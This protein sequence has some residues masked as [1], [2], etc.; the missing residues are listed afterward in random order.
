MFSKHLYVL[1]IFLETLNINDLPTEVAELQAMIVALHEELQ[2]LKAELATLQGGNGDREKALKAR[3]DDLERRLFGKKKERIKP[4]DGLEPKKD[5]AAPHGRKPISPRLT[6]D[7]NTVEP[8]EATQP[9][10]SCGKA[11]VRMGEETSEQVHWIP[12]RLVVN[13]HVRGRWACSCGECPISIAP[14][15]SHPLQH[16]MF[17]MS[18]IAMLIEQKYANHMPVNRTLTML[19]HQGGDFH[20][21]TMLDQVK[22]GAEL[23]RPIVEEMRKQRKLLPVL[24][25]DDTGLLVLDNKKDKA[26]KGYLWIYVG[27]SELGIPI[28]AT[29][30]Y[31]P[32]R[33]GDQPAGPHVVLDGYTGVIISDAATAMDAL[34]G[35]GKATEGGCWMHGRRGFYEALTEYK[36]EAE[37]AVRQIHGIFMA[38]RKAKAEGMTVDQRREL[39]QRVSR[40]ILDAFEAWCDKLRPTVIPKGKLGSALTYVFN[41]RKA[42]RTF[43]DD[44]RIE[45]DNGYAERGLRGP[46]MGRRNWIFAGSDEAAKRA[47]ILY[48]LTTSCRL[49]GID[50]FKYLE[51]VLERVSDHPM[52]RIAELTPLGWAEIRARE[53]L[54]ASEPPPG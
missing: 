14:A 19:R 46:A 35:D 22:H 36:A 40:P 26:K 18:F 47:A 10:P 48:S 5:A 51:D 39:R 24:H 16:G 33:K 7:T 52:S 32:T 30:E 21:N 27:M 23:L 8:P 11:R 12:G 54:K 6:R 44:G 13:R 9:C 15:L 1:S 37:D 29:F 31:T 2:F 38:E 4:P 41:Q 53:S 50:P 45:L 43:L 3:I 20:L 17:T 25:V 28:Q 49:L 34:Y 42:L